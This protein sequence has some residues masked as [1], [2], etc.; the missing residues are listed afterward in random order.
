MRGVSM[1]VKNTPETVGNEGNVQLRG[2]FLLFYAFDVGEEINLK[3][4]QNSKSIP[5]FV[6]PSSPGFKNYHIPVSV[7][8][9]DCDPHAAG[10]ARTDCIAAKIHS[11]GVLSL[12]Y[13]IPFTG[14]FEELKS[15]FIE[16]AGVYTEKSEIDATTLFNAVKKYITKP[17]FFNMVEHYSAVQV[18]PFDVMTAETFKHTFGSKIASLLRYEK[19]SLS[20]YQQ[21]AVLASSSG[22]YG[23]DMVIID[24]EAA[25]IYDD[26]YYE[27]LEF[28]EFVNIQRLELKYFDRALDAQLNKFYSGDTAYELSWSSYIP[29]IKGKEDR[30]IEELARLRVDISVIIDRLEVSIKMSG[31]PY[32]EEIYSM[33]V[34]KLLIPQWLD[35]VNKKLSI[36]QDLYT[37][38]RDRLAGIRGELLTVVIIVL[39]GIE[40]FF[41]FLHLR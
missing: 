22:Y 16:I 21:E 36:I 12:C 19:E 8:L 11:F 35:S 34:D 41:A 5:S 10:R 25:L 29:M 37:V 32:H 2:N 31:D 3:A 23:Q 7:Q 20:E 30:L 33:L 27:V 39:V 24:G 17:H 9:A 14:N 38:Y 18:A 6:L 40:A 1:S 26:E 28:L 13:K 4:L 15:R